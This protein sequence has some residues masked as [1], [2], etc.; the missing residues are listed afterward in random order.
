[1]FS[2]LISRRLEISSISRVNPAK[3]LM[4]RSLPITSEIMTSSVSSLAGSLLCCLD[5]GRTMLGRF[6]IGF[7]STLG[8]EITTRDLPLLLVVES[9]ITRNVRA[10]G[11]ASSSVRGLRLIDDFMM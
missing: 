7:C 8:V 11:R 10:Y 4:L 9:L 5:E 1:M 3:M 6:M 2:P